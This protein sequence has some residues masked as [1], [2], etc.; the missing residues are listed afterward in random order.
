MKT[1]RPSRGRPPSEGPELFAHPPSEGPEH[2][3]HPPSEGPEHFAHSSG[4][5]RRAIF[6]KGILTVSRHGWLEFFVKRKQYGGIIIKPV[7][8]SITLLLSQRFINF[9]GR[10]ITRKSDPMREKDFSKY[11]LVI[12]IVALAILVFLLIRPF[13]GAILGS[14]ALTYLFFPVYRWISLK[15][16]RENLSSFLTCAF[17]IILLFV[18]LAFILNTLSREAYVGYLVSKQ[19]IVGIEN[20]IADCQQQNAFC[21]TLNYFRGILSQPKVK[22]YIQTTIE[23]V[24]TYIVKVISDLVF[25]I[26]HLIL[27]FFI[28]IFLTFYL[29]KD[30]KRL[31]AKIKHVL[32]LRPSYKDHLFNRIEKVTYA[33][34]FG[35]LI[36]ALI[37]GAVA[38]I[39]FFIFQIS[40]P[41]TWGAVVAFL[42]LIPFVGPT[43]IWLPASL[44]KILSGALSHNT[45]EWV[46]G[47]LL[48]AYGFFIISGIDNILRPKIIGEKGNIH[49]FVVLI[50]VLGGLPIFGLVGIFAGPLVLAITITLLEL[51]ANER[52]AK[53]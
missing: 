14:F 33:V 45:G 41:I 43:L 12:I 29:F 40:S 24:T 38:A 9:Q 46:G 20:L 52:G 1:A 23:K 28:L 2:F 17:I 49:P 31:I 26:P 25:S 11:L 16:G 18:P 53:E 10:K 37:Q 15:T 42:A 7:Q 8:Q 36:V 6:P 35:Y 21:S 51:Y 50:G 34:T 19:K 39:G 30:G 13:V 48:A 27:N 22:Y 44:I 4:V 47:L 32:P 5:P 3:A